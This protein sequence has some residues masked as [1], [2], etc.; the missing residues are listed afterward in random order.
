MELKLSAYSCA[1]IGTFVDVIDSIVFSVLPTFAFI[2]F[3]CSILMNVPL[4]N[5]LIVWL[6]VMLFELLIIQ[7]SISWTHTHRIASYTHTW[8]E[9]SFSWCIQSRNEY[10][11]DS[12][13]CDKTV[14][15]QVIHWY[16][17]CKYAYSLVRL[18]CNIC[19]NVIRS[20]PGFYLQNSTS[21]TGAFV[22]NVL[23]SLISSFLSF[24]LSCLSVFLSMFSCSR[25]L[26]SVAFRRKVGALTKPQRK[27]IACITT[28]R[29]HVTMV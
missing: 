22:F 11:V 23:L 20:K 15:I 7:M 1:H 2:S 26:C 8:F 6:F 10:V 29:M 21:F 28:I 25:L 4:M 14:T 17:A 3:V 19:A 9:V 12:A 13:E 24:F 5:Q 16:I 27:T 18:K